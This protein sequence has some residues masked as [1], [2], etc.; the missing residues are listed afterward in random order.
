MSFIPTLKTTLGVAFILAIA[1]AISVRA[2]TQAVAD[3]P[4]TNVPA[5]AS[6]TGELKKSPSLQSTIAPVENT[7]SDNTSETKRDTGSPGV[8]DPNTVTTVPAVSAKAPG[9]R[10]KVAVPRGTST[11][12]WE[13]QFTPYFWLAGLHGNAGIGNRTTQVDESFGDIFHVLNFTFMGVLEARKGKLVSLTDL[14]Y[15]NISD[16][17]ATPGPLFSN[18]DAQF[19]TF[20]FDPEVGYRVL[21]NPDKGAF[22]DV[23]GGVRVWHVSTDLAFGAG[24]LPATEVQ[25]SRNWVDG[26][27]GLRGKMALS[28]KLFLT[29]KFDLGGGGSKF[30]YQVFAGGGYNV[31]KRVALIFGYRVL[32]V[33][34][35]KDGFLYDMNQRGPIIGLGFKF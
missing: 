2:Q 32:D 29:G 23:L 28:P 30:T 7:A 21:D 11:D 25:R 6:R 33:D 20:I 14:E 19:K 5:N 16:N 22:I 9:S 24:I 4:A 35:N 13:F 10:G 27:A 8:V 12:K 15:V 3:N 17:K 26:V 18:V 1:S 31:N 34:Y